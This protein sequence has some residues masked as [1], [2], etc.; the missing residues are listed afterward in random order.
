MKID[1]IEM[2]F[3]IVLGIGAFLYFKEILYNEDKRYTENLKSNSLLCLF[4]MIIT[5][6]FPIYYMCMNGVSFKMLTLFIISIGLGWSCMIDFKLQELPDSVSK[7]FMII[8]F[9]LF[10]VGENNQEKT[11]QAISIAIVVGVMLILWKFVGGLGFGDIKLIVPIMLSLPVS[12]YLAFLCNSL[13][14]AFIYAIGLLI[15]KKVGEDRRFA[16]GPFLIGGFYLTMFGID[17]LGM[18]TTYIIS[19]L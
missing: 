7:L 1:L 13:I 10:I 2:L 4:C 9:C 11:Y 19:V 15:F 8:A 5:A 12:S 17:F 14:V 6:S 16:F 18:L 3:I